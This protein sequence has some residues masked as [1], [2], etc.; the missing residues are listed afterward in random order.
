MT[1][2]D[3]GLS[4]HYI[5]KNGMSYKVASKYFKAPELLLGCDYYNY[6]IDIWGVGIIFASIVN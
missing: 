6:E 4:E 5:P 3:F 2:I 1:L